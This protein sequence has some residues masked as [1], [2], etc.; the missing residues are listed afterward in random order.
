MKR[1]S[2]LFFMI[3]QTILT[4]KIYSQEN[5]I[6]FP[7]T[8]EKKYLIFV[9]GE[10]AN[11]DISEFYTWDESFLIEVVNKN[12]YLPVEY[13]LQ[14]DIHKKH[15]DDA[16]GYYGPPLFWSLMKGN[17]EIS[18]L[19][20][21]NGANPNFKIRDGLSAFELIDEFVK[22]KRVPEWKANE[23]KQLLLDYGYGYDNWNE[24]KPG[25]SVSAKENLRL[26]TVEL[27]SSPIITTIKKNTFVKVKL[28]GKFD[29]IDGINSRCVYV[30]VQN[31][32]QDNT[33][34]LIKNGTEGWC[35]AGYLNDKGIKK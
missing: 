25:I 31:G 14:F 26:R 12:F 13:V 20:L 23:L 21:R 8:S 35:F 1:T 2:I 19:L 33:G 30:E 11:R 34:K 16:S 7:V 9:K 3:L 4:S 22:D 6:D 27:I 5:K 15:I 29:C 28:I 32:A 10:C 17:K 18:E 24:I